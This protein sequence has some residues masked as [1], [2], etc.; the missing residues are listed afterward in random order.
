MADLCEVSLRQRI[1]QSGTALWLSAGKLVRAW[2][3]LLFITPSTFQRFFIHEGVFKTKHRMLASFFF[4]C[5]LSWCWGLPT[6]IA[7]V[8]KARCS[9]SDLVPTE[10]NSQDCG[11]E[12]L[13]LE[14]FACESWGLC[15][16]CLD[17]DKSRNCPRKMTSW[18]DKRAALKIARLRSSSCHHTPIQTTALMVLEC[19]TE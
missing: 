6:C 13:T 4:N 18:Q 7:Q 10:G 11:N 16:M 2:A 5:C 14:C 8:P 1:S 15:N 17:R 19:L 12:C 9:L 3:A